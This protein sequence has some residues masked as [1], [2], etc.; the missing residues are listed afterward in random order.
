MNIFSSKI[1]K[2][3]KIE[4]ANVSTVV[5]V[6]T[7]HVNIAVRRGVVPLSTFSAQDQFKLK[8]GESIAYD[9]AIAR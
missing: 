4:I 7:G 6:N 1:T 8:R 5:S 2:N 9:E 3:G